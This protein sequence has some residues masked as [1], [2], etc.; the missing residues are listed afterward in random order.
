MGL[1]GIIVSTTDV[2]LREVWCVVIEGYS[3]KRLTKLT[4]FS[5]K[6]VALSGLAS[7]LG[8]S[9]DGEDSFGGLVCLE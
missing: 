9:W 8:R 1:P 3:A 7:D 6:L 5:D 4:K 2:A